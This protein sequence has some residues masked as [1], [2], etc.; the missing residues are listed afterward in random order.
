VIPFIGPIPDANMTPGRDGKAFRFA[1]ANDPVFIVL[2]TMAGTVASTDARFKKPQ[3][4]ASAH[5]GVGLNG[6]V[7]QW[8]REPD[9]AYH[10]GSLTMNLAS[11]GIEHEDGGDAGAPRS[12]ALYAATSSLIRDICERYAIPITRQWIVKH[13]EVPGVATA[14]PDALDV[15]R[16]V[17]MAAS[18]SVGQP[19][20]HAAGAVA[21]ETIVPDTPPKTAG[22]TDGASARPAVAATP[23]PVAA[24]E[25][26]ASSI[27][28]DAGRWLDIYH[29]IQGVVEDAPLVKLLDKVRAGNSDAPAGAPAPVRISSPGDSD[30]QARD[31]LG[32]KSAVFGVQI[33]YLTILAT[34]AIIY[35][36]DRNMLDLPPT[37][38]PVPEPVP[39]FGALG[40]VLIS[41]VGIT[42]HMHD[43]DP[44]YRFWHWS[45]PLLGASFGTISVLIFQAGILAVGTQ[46]AI[47]GG[48][49][50]KDLLYYL[51]AF[52]VGYRE[53]TFREL[54]KRLTDVIFSP[55][56]DGGTVVVNS[57]APQTGPASGGTTIMLLGSGFDSTDA[58]RFGSVQAT[59]HIDG[60]GQ[61]T[62]T[63]PPG[64][65]GAT[66][67][68]SVTAKSASAIAGAFTYA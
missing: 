21:T 15:D 47:N 64:Q 42:E 65:A 43:W 18:S 68:V 62:V 13:S 22:A 25:D 7:V 16:I 20:L 8:V 67:T 66:V 35:F 19:S 48:G 57:M 31:P 4:K 51:I 63:C 55:G 44:A 29:A 14:C 58:V 38:G 41:L 52:V 34:L 45:R 53:E 32:S 46:P 12:E 5:Y 54:I 6:S 49:V 61:L 50:S 36:V 23:P 24:L 26:I 60:D 9:T 33:V 37:L 59:F 17:S 1:G 39:W 56:Q 11:I 10:A 40:A 2:H 30:A 3:S 27:Y 28:G